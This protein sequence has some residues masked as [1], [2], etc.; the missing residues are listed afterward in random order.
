MLRFGQKEVTTK[1]FYGQRQITDVFTI[2]VNKVVVSDKVSCNNGKECR[3]TVGHQING[4]LIPL[5]I[6]TP[7]NIFSYGVSQYDKNSTYKMSFN[8]SE[9]KQWVFQYKK[10]WNELEPQLFE[11]LAS[12]PIKGG[13]KYVHGTL[14]MW[15][16][17]IKTNFHGQDVPYDMYCNAT[18]VLK[19]DSVYKQ[20]KNY[21]PQ[22]YL[23]ECKYTDAENQECNMLNGDDD[24]HGFFEV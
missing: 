15:K 18:A 4:A 19:I 11:T 10:I 9:T 22:V 21:H 8:V 20:G 24:D 3:Y 6:N 2:D 23:E 12:E 13:D 14:K 7:K 17:H 1:D 16:E 5:F